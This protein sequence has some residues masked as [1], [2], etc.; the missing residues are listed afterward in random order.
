MKI[1]NKKY[2]LWGIFFFIPLPLFVLGVI[3]ADLWQWFLA[4]GLSAKFLFA[5]LSEQEAKRQDKIEMNYE[6]VSQ[7][8]FGK[9]AGLKT[10]LP[11]LLTGVF[12]AVTLLIRFLFDLVIPVWVAVCFVLAL[13]ISVF[14]SIGLHREIIK[15][16]DQETS[17]N[18]KVD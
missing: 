1:Y 18:D 16:I 2:F 17:S 9:Y 6:R 12:F 4:I 7:K 13:T 10:N 8:L 11:W 15:H 5:G 14:Y 3:K